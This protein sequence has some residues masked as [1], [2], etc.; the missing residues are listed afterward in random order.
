MKKHSK[1]KMTTEDKCKRRRIMIL[2][3]DESIIEEIQR[4]KNAAL[5]KSVI[6]ESQEDEMEFANQ[7]VRF[8]RN[9]NENQNVEKVSFS[10]LQIE[11]LQPTPKKLKDTSLICVICGAPALGFNFDAVSCES[12]KSFFRRNALKD[13]VGFESKIDVFS[14][15]T[16]RFLAFTMFSTRK[17]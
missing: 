16:F 4:S 15:F 6:L 3:G 13:P 17:L 10:L 14:F 11:F 9:R 8:L 1:Q 7:R 5:C 12:C 2:S